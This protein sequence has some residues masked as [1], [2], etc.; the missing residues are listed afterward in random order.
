MISKQSIVDFESLTV[1]E[2]KAIQ[3]LIDI[4]EKKPAALFGADKTSDD[5]LNLLR[6]VLERLSHDLSLPT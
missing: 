5:I 4:M 6:G 2:R 1:E 3:L